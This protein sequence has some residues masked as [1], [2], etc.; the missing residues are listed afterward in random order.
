MKEL[1]FYNG[2]YGELSEMKIPMNDRVCF[3]GDG[4]YDATYSRNYS[5]FALD[6]HVDRFF[7]SA[8]LMEIPLHFTKEE[9]K[10]ILQH[11]VYKLEDD[12]QF[13]YWQVT[14]GT[15]PRDHVFPDQSVKPNLW[16]VLKPRKIVDI[17]KKERLI[18]IEDTRYYHCNV[19]TLNLMPNVIAA[20]RTLEADCDE[21]VF[22]RGKWVTECAH[23]NINILKDGVFQTHPTDQFVLPGISRKHL[24]QICHS[25]GI[26]VKEK[27][28]TVQ[29]MMKA[30]EIIV[31]S[32][33]QLC[34]QVVEIDG[35]PVGGK[36][37]D[38]LKKLQDT[39]LTKF[40]NETSLL[41]D[42]LRKDQ[43]CL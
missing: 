31:S 34:L 16:V 15:G 42:A 5:I 41:Y 29:E 3:F 9:L 12:E 8:K 10:D 18:T 28:F 13:V 33:G 19:K 1:G 14:R 6:E 24:I 40:Y 35:Q 26:P 2:R 39:Y 20:Q 21:C 4:V 36:D 27:A 37:P 43:G 17:H 11:L 7:Q 22:H 38:L 23:S 32:S 25:F 30:D